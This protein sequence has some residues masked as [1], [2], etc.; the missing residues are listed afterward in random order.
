MQA[1]NITSF[2]R[3]MTWRCPDVA[4]LLLHLPPQANTH[5]VAR[6]AAAAPLTV[7]QLF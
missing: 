1:L 7:M 3:L 2:Q 5:C 6:M 4:Q